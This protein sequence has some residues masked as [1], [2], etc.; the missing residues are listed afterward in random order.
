MPSIRRLGRAL[1]GRSP[2]HERNPRS[3][4]KRPVDVRENRDRGKCF[5]LR[6]LAEL[7]TWYG[8]HS[9]GIVKAQWRRDDDPSDLI[10]LDP[11]KHS[12]LVHLP[13]VPDL[14][15]VAH[16]GAGDTVLLEM[17]E[18]E[19]FEPPVPLATESVL[20]RRKGQSR[21]C[22]YL[23]GTDGS[24]LL[25]SAGESG[26]GVSGKLAMPPMGQREGAACEAGAGSGD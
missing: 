13:I 20:P 12:A 3:G 11:F 7:G 6:R 24:N 9:V 26:R 16:R 14:A 21:K 2:H 4:S 10:V 17:A 18:G 8:R 15:D 22:R 19:G 23:A 1:P 25:P 5:R